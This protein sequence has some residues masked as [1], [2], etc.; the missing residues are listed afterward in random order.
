MKKSVLIIL[1]I[2]VIIIGSFV[3]LA[4]STYSEGARAGTLTKYSSKGLLRRT[5]EGEL[6]L[7]MNSS[8]INVSEAQG[9]VIENPWKFSSS[10]EIYEANRHY[11]DTSVYIEYRQPYIAIGWWGDT[12]YR[13]RDISPLLDLKPES[14]GT[15][16]Q[17]GQR[18]EGSRVGRIVK[19][20]TKGLFN[21]HEIIIQMGEMGNQFIAMSIIDDEILSCAF[22]FMMSGTKVKIHYEDDYIRNPL[23]QK[24]SYTVTGIWNQ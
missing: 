24:T 15:E 3:F 16:G 23:V 11:L 8:D 12:N 4:T 22:Q 5:G 7:G 2:I 17:S 1:S 21:T 13:V 10:E 19:V 18:S 20:S 6:Q 14:C 9:Q